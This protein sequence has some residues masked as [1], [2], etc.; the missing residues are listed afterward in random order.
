MA[1]FNLTS[2]ARQ[3]TTAGANAGT[4]REREPSPYDG[5]WLNLGT[6]IEGPDGKDK[7]IRL[8]RGVAVSDLEKHK[9]Y[10]STRE[11]NPNWAAEADMVNAIIDAIQEACATMEEGDSVDLNLSLQLYRKQEAVEAPATSINMDALKQ[12]LFK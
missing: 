7:F 6:S 1:K 9:V 12:Q 5:F 10:A 8:P 3:E 11:N 4:R 2:A